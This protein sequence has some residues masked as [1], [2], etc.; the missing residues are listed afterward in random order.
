[1][2]KANNKKIT[3]NVNNCSWKHHLSNGGWGW[4]SDIIHE[5]FHSNN[6]SID[7]HT[8]YEYQIRGSLLTRPCVAFF[9]QIVTGYVRSLENLAAHKTWPHNKNKI[10]G[11]IT[12]S[13]EQ[14]QFLKNH[15]ID[16][17][18]CILHPTRLDVPLWNAN[19]FKKTK[20]II[21]AGI[22]CRDL[23]ILSQL[24]QNAV[25]NLNYM[26]IIAKDIAPQKINKAIHVL[27]RLPDQEF[28]NLL[29]SSIVFLQLSAATANNTVLECI[30]RGTPVVINPMGGIPEYLGK[31]YPLYYTNFNEAKQLILSFKNDPDI[32]LKAHNYLLAIRSKYNKDNFIKN[33]NKIFNNWS[34]EK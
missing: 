8:A 11:A 17:V 10:W 18:A 27:D 3:F 14:K 6:A 30:A 24:A 7:L 29:T 12:V 28:D 31:E 22:H 15:G 32:L 4:V 26:Y 23:T 33:L 13:Q 19:Q 25:G 20:R 2:F 5:N 21:H 34:Y 16:Q 1:M 9:H